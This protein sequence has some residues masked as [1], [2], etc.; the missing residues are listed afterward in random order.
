MIL[1]RFYFSSL[2]EGHTTK[3]LL[4]CEA[5]ECYTRYFVLGHRISQ[6]LLCKK[7]SLNLRNVHSWL[8]GWAGVALLCVAHAARVGGN[9]SN[10]RWQVYRI[11]ILPLSTSHLGTCLCPGE[12]APLRYPATGIL[13]SQTCPL[14][15]LWLPFHAHGGAARPVGCSQPRTEFKERRHQWRSIPGR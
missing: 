3:H 2:P 15:L 13:P 9:G 8:C 14:L 7:Q 11:S 10:I 4:V 5:E 6:L 12:N 1:P